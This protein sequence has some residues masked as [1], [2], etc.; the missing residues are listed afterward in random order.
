MRGIVP[1]NLAACQHDEQM[2]GGSAVKPAGD[3]TLHPFRGSGLGRGQQEEVFR[4]QKRRLDR[5]PQ[6]GRDG[7]AGFVAEHPHGAQPVP[8]LRKAVQRRP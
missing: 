8:R 2:I 1:A 5:R 3:F 7:K 6:S 4:I